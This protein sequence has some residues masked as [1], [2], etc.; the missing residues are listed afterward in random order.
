M[1]HS[2]LLELYQANLSLETFPVAV[3]DLLQQA[4]G[5]DM[6]MYGEVD[7][8][9]SETRGICTDTSPEVAAALAEY[10]PHNSLHPFFQADPSFYAERV[11]FL[12]DCLTEM[13]LGKD[14]TFTAV[15]DPIGVHDIL[16]FN[17]RFGTKVI[18][19]GAMRRFEAPYKETERSVGQ[20]LR[21]HFE[22]LYGQTSAR[23]SQKLTLRER[24]QMVYPTLTARQ[25]DVAS[26]LAMGKSN[27]VIAHLLNVSQA[28]VKFHLRSIFN[29]IGAED[30]TTAALLLS[31][32]SPDFIPTNLPQASACLA[33][34]KPRRARGS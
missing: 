1:V 21:S 9:T 5:S 7:H 19:L 23:A 12:R 29:Q 28:G 18:A 13:E 30:R 4:T 2:R 8:A 17:F 10:P 11:L 26:W 27:A 6:A 14:A 15:Y 20:T 3:V 31:Q 24:I 25:L 16:A 33:K 32:A 34:K 22:V